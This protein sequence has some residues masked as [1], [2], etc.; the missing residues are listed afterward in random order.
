MDINLFNYDLPPDL[1]AQHPAA[2]RDE[3][4]LMIL[5]RTTG[6]IEIRRFVDF[7]DYI[8]SGDA[9]VV[10][11]TKVFKARLI[12]KRSTGGEVEVFLVRN[13]PDNP[14]MW[15]AMVRPSRRVKAGENILFPGTTQAEHLNLNLRENRGGRWL[16]EFPSGKSQETIIDRYGHVPLP[17]YIKRPDVPDDVERYQTIFARPDRTGAVAAPTAG[18]HFTPSILARLRE[19]GVRI[20]ELTLHVGPGTFKPVRVDDIERHTVDPEFA[21][22]PRSAAE[23]VNDVR[24]GG[25][26]VFV[27]GT[28]SVRTLESAEGDGGE[29]E[30]FTG[31]VDLY[32]RPGHRFRFVDHLLTN[33]HLPKSSLLILVSAFA[34][35]KLILEAYEKAVENRF[36]FY[37]YGDAMLIL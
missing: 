4:R 8:S 2:E 37:S 34:G 14:L 20:A 25:G 5:D 23:I 36:R 35:R 13:R 29:I 31:E 9:L 32:I 18:F 7:C 27:V 1:I 28:T 19:G 33:F 17:Q 30:P 11:N 26:R 21:D 10:N 15:E 6:K 16:V 12:G 24:R 22:L 3:S